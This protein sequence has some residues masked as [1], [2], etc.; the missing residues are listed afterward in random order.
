[1][2]I[3]LLEAN[4]IVDIFVNVNSLHG[5]AALTGVVEG[6]KVQPVDNTCD[7]RVFVNDASGIATKFEELNS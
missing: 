6:A 4:Y 3:I 5:N 7:I 1:M 2:L